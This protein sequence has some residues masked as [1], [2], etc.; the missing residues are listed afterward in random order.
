M[1]IKKLMERPRGLYNNTFN[2]ND[3]HHSIVS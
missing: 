2:A 3:R 1:D